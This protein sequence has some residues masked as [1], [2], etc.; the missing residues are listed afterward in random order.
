MYDG[1]RQTERDERMKL[2]AY[3]FLPNDSLRAAQ[4]NLYG[5][6][7]ENRKKEKQRASG[8]AFM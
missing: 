1:E 6:K 7:R 4:K 8:I 5:C 2:D 3:N